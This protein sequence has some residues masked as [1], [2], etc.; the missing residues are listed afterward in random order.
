MRHRKR[1]STLRPDDLVAIV[2][3]ELRTP[4]TALRLQLDTAI[5][6]AR[7]TEVPSE[8]IGERL[9]AARRQVDRL[10]KLVEQLLDASRL[11]VGKLHLELEPVDAMEVVRDV[12]DRCAEI[13][14]RARCPIEIVGP[15]EV[16][17]M[18]NRLA[19]E[20]VVT[21]LL[22]NATKFG[23]AKPIRIEVQADERRAV[24]RITDGGI[25]IAP[26]NQARIFE[27][28]EQVAGRR[29]PGGLG[30]GLWIVDRIVTSLGGK[31]RIESRLGQGATFI[32]E[33]PRHLGG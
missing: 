6:E 19:F 22:V 11:S 16:V 2:A 20:Q 25:G 10:V 18:W 21:N 27:R 12:V 32:V 33:L 17:G 29:R 4:L 8:P 24:L 31:V 3:H 7:E 23:R 26:A 15:R 5:H 14:A 13:V 9:E 1:P 30:L 28:Y